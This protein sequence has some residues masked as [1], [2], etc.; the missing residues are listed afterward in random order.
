MEKADA[1]CLHPDALFGSVSNGF[2]SLPFQQ[3]AAS[4]LIIYCGS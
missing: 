1:A 2:G 4:R 3:Q